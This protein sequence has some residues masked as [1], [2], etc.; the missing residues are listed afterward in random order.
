[1][2]NLFGTL[3][4]LTRVR[5][6]RPLIVSWIEASRPAGH[7]SGIFEFRLKKDD[8]LVRESL[9]RPNNV[10]MVSEILSEVTG[11]ETKPSYSLV[12]HL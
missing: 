3:E 5:Q 2:E 9:S 11:I 1:M 7:S 4:L 6:K 8:S 10:K 12:N